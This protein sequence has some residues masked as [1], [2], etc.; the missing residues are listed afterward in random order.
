MILYRHLHLEL[1]KISR[2]IDSIFVTQL[3]FKMACYF[4]WLVFDVRTFFCTIL[5]DNYVKSD[6]IMCVVI[7]ILWFS[8][9]VFKFLLINYMCETVRTKVLILYLISNNIYLILKN[10]FQPKFNKIKFYFKL[11]NYKQFLI[12][13]IYS[14]IH[15]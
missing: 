2:E 14:N 1:R 13:L 4:S 5:I 12:Y 7:N 6:K 8:N 3:S 11:L 9:N 10:C 15:I